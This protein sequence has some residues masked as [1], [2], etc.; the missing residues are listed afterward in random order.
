V[1]TLVRFGVWSVNA[2]G[3]LVDLVA[4]TPNDITMLS[5]NFTDYTKAFTT[6]WRKVTGER[7]AVG[8]LAVG[9]APFVYG[10]SFFEYNVHERRAPWVVYSLGGLTDLPATAAVGILGASTFAPQFS[11]LP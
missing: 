4:S 2:A 1:T 10:T 8:V 6:P 5:A 9:A 7:Y 11:L 3:D